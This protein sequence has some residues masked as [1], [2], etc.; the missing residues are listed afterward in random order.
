MWNVLHRSLKPNPITFFAFLNQDRSGESVMRNRA[1]IYRQKAQECERAVT[2]VADPQVQASYR[3]IAN[4]MKWLRGSRRS[5]R[6][7]LNCLSRWNVERTLKSDPA[8]P[9][10]PTA[11]SYCP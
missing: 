1:D 5:M 2:R 11:K 8:L 10:D 9:A 3:Q 6:R 4:G 7:W